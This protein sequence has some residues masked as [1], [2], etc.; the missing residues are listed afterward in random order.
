MLAD[1]VTESKN[2]G[3]ADHVMESQNVGLSNMEKNLIVT[4][5]HMV[6]ANENPQV[7]YMNVKVKDYLPK[8]RTAKDV[9]DYD[10]LLGDQFLRSDSLPSIFTNHRRRVDASG[11]MPWSACKYGITL[12]SFMS[13]CSHR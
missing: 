10:V 3:L 13:C 1:H 6:V 8:L 2:V 4:T 11:D 9:L 12:L 7:T 5:M